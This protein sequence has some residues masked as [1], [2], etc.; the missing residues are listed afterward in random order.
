MGFRAKTQP[1]G[2]GVKGLELILSRR[3]VG[4]ERQAKQVRPELLS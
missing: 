3:V 4:Q 2:T 1:G